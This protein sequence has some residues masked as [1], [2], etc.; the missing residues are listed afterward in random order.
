MLSLVPVSLKDANAFVAAHHRHHRPVTGHKFSIGCEQDGR[1]VGV[2]IVGR[3]VS[4]YLDNGLTLEVTRL[5]TTGEKNACSMLYAAAARARRPS[6][7]AGSS[8]IRWTPK[9]GPASGRLAG[10]V[11]GGQGENA[12][13]AIAVPLWTSAR[14]R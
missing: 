5:C 9:L 1:L 11:W 7:T 4:R 13:P 14:R 3:P 12:G 6:A 2:A 8:P 10:L